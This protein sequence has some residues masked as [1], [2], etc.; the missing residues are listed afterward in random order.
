MPG[1]IEDRW[2][3]KK[4]DPVTGKH[5]R[6]AR[7]GIG[8]RYKV[9]GI[10]GVADRSFSLLGDAKTWLSTS[11]T[12]S[13]RGT[14]IDPRDGN[15]T[16]R[17]YVEKKWWPTLR[18]PPGT[19]E[20]MRP[21]VF[22]HILPHV[23]HMML[24]Q[25]GSDEI[26]EW[27]T[28]AEKDI[29]VNTLRT[30][31]RHFSS[32]MQAAHKAKRIAANPFRDPD[33]KAPKKPP[34]KAKAWSPE[35]VAAVRRALARRYRVLVDLS[36]GSGIRQGEAF[37]FSPDDMDGEVIQV[38]RQVV[39]IGGKLAFAPPKGNKPREA[40]CPPELAEAVNAHIEEFGTVSVTLPW[41]DPDRPNLPWDKRPLV[42]V[43]LLVTTT[44][45]GGK[46]GGAIN[47][48][49]FDEK[50]WK[51]ALAAAGV[52]PEP[53]ITVILRPG[54]PSLR[55]VK[56]A[57][58]REDGFHV[59][60][61]TFASVV[62]AA[63]ETIIQLAAWLGHS[64]PAFTLR[65]YVHFMPKSGARGVA[66]LGSLLAFAARTAVQ[67]QSVPADSPQILPTAQKEAPAEPVF[68][69]QRGLEADESACTPGSGFLVIGVDAVLTGHP[70]RV[71]QLPLRHGG[72]I[73][74][75]RRPRCHERGPG[76]ADPLPHR[77]GE[78]AHGA[79]KGNG[80]KDSSSLG[81]IHGF[82]P[83]PS[84]LSRCAAPPAGATG[85]SAG[86]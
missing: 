23:G 27:Q 6:T 49:T 38:T 61:H 12:D 29:D 45:T 19:K 18:V 1:Y 48:S 74:I 42:T 28:R 54:R 24:N 75:G 37:G 83:A 14:F 59:L 44:H 50:H 20:T 31:W 68:A 69:G 8:K 80:G 46:S 64:D 43:R 2:L 13:T 33:L 10:P 26:K 76:F 79:P 70:Q 21:R 77:I 22:R 63:G 71:L 16:L 72:P 84:G 34:S 66:A 32:I 47:R 4:K 39:K 40:P 41:V 36:A 3:T 15:V 5:K 51:P 52:I 85:G 78:H 65:T 9:A 56:W 7:Y 17:W 35:R 11:Q 62:L 82:A 60:R 86:P 67:T 73:G 55:R 30:A 25:I 81:S 53:E 57:M 58:L